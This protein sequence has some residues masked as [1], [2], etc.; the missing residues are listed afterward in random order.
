M[1]EKPRHEMA[2]VREDGVI[3][4]PPSMLHDP[5][6]DPENPLPPLEPGGPP[7]DRLRA[8]LMLLVAEHERRKREVKP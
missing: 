7:L 6:F 1:P 4:I 3:L 2:E 8:F 5:V